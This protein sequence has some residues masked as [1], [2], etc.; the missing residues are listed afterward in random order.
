[1]PVAFSFLFLNFEYFTFLRQNYHYN[2]KGLIVLKNKN[3][4]ASK[5][6]YIVLALCVLV[7]GFGAVSSI[8]TKIAE[9]A[10]N[11]TKLETMYD[12]S[13]Q[14]EVITE[15]QKA[16][17]PATD[18]PDTRETTTA[19]YFSTTKEPTDKLPYKG[20]FSLPLGTSIIKDYSDGEMVKFKTMDDWR[21]HN[22]IDFKG[23]KDMSVRSITDGIVLSVDNDAMW[24]TVVTVD[25]G[26]G[27]VAKY[28]GLNP[29]DC[30]KK[31]TVLKKND[32]I[33]TLGIIPIEKLD[34]YHLHFEISV[35]GKYDD[36]LLVMN[37]ANKNE[38]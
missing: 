28:C 10:T 25:H 19:K 35:S 5:T 22:G 9:K 16:N 17:L 14:T 34:G 24:G 23:E 13:N 38:N 7:S 6:F 1:M 30:V 33:G 4:Y 3:L 31:D 20:E 37:K 15:E 29:D 11:T 12:W 2:T 26:K 32:I 36:P 21:V 8:K 18:I 27:M